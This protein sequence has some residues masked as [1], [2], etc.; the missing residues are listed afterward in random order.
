MAEHDTSVDTGSGHTLDFAPGGSD[1]GD[2]QHTYQ[3]FLRIIR[4]SILAIVILLILL[5]WIVY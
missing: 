5:A 4:W 1:Y 2:H 3:G